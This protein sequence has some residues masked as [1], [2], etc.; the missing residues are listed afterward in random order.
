M[1]K[2]AIFVKK[3]SNKHLKNRKYRKTRNHYQY[4]REYEGDLYNIYNLA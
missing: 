4:A 2:L 1:Q 3:S